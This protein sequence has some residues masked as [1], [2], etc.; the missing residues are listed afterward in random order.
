MVE[1]ESRPT[2]QAPS[3]TLTALFVVMFVAS[4][5]AVAASYFVR[6]IAMGRSIQFAFVMFTLTAPTLL[7]VV[8]SWFVKLMLW[9]G[10]PR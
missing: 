3:F 6:G 8:A 7:I 1:S 4:M 2:S 9:I 10:R 5:M